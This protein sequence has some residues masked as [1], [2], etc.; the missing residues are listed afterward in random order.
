MPQKVQKCIASWQHFLPHYKIQRWDET[1]FDIKHA[2]RFVQEAYECGKFAFV[3]DY[4][5]F[6]VLKKIGG[7]YLDTDVEVIRSFSDDLLNNDLVLVLDDGGYISGS[8]ILCEPGNPFINDCLEHYHNIPFVRND[9]SFS[10]EVINTHMQN[11]LKHS[12]YRIINNHQLL[13][14]KGSRIQIYPDEYF[15]VRSLSTGKLNLTKNSYAIHWHTILWVSQKTKIINFL[16]I[17]FLIPL[18]GQKVY[19][20]ITQR[21]K[22]G[23]SS[24]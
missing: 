17:H 14:Y 21:I 1:N 4:V 23:K 9:G 2:C 22:H 13:E 10:M 11:K 16:R 19:K 7:I 6:Y 3:S 18:L 15:H 12:G 8:T 24:I 20:R 5:R